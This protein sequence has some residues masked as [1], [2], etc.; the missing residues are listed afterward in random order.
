MFVHLWIPELLAA[1]SDSLCGGVKLGI[2]LYQQL[3]SFSHQQSCWDTSLVTASSLYLYHTGDT[4]KD[5][6]AHSPCAKAGPLIVVSSQWHPDNKKHRNNK[7]DFMSSQKMESEF[8]DM[9]HVSP[10]WVTSGERRG[11]RGER[12]GDSRQRL[13]HVLISANKGVVSLF[14]PLLSLS[15]SRE[16]RCW[17][18]ALLLSCGRQNGLLGNLSGQVEERSAASSVAVFPPIVFTFCLFAE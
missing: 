4:A 2:L 7:A 13:Q 5:R 16:E 8:T 12:I 6:L 1:E 9:Y 17:L 10:G 15:A 3:F 18:F 11:R 14:F